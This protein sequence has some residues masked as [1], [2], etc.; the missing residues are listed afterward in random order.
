MLTWSTR[1]AIL[2]A[3]TTIALAGGGGTFTVKGKTRTL[4]SAYAYSR[5]DPFDNSKQSTA[6]VFSERVIDIA[7]INAAEDRVEALEH[8]INDYFPDQ[9]TKP[10]SVDI[11][12]ARDDPQAPIQQ[13]G[14]DLPG[15]SS[16]A[17]TGAGNYTLTL[18]RNDAKRIE[19]TLRSTKEA[20]KTAEHGGYFD[21]HFALDVASPTSG[22]N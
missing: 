13:I 12:I 9:E 14:F 3:A 17:S 18:K 2:L 8:A 19:G 10:S 7:K 21:L 6:I 20:A 1:A 11:I 5:P 15:L 22:S 4:K 16:S